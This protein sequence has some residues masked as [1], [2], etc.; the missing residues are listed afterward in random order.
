M[1]PDLSPEEELLIGQIMKLKYREAQLQFLGNV[2]SIVCPLS[3]LAISVLDAF[4]QSNLF[5]LLTFL[6]YP[7]SIIAMS[8]NRTSRA[9]GAYLPVFLLVIS[10]FLLKAT[11]LVFLCVAGIAA[12][13]HMIFNALPVIRLQC[14]SIQQSSLYSSVRSKISSNE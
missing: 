7:A 9:I 2:L 3:L 4:S 6:A 13:Y 5:R 8:I 10:L 11:F 1:V 14:E 12:A